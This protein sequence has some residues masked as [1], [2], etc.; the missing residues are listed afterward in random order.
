MATK[1]PDSRKIQP[2]MLAPISRPKVGETG[3]AGR[4]WRSL[5]SL[6]V[7]AVGLSFSVRAHAFSF[8]GVSAGATYPTPIGYVYQTLNNSVGGQAESWI[9]FGFLN[10]SN[11]LFHFGADVEPYN[12]RNTSINI[13]MAEIFAGMQFQNGV[14]GAGFLPYFSI[15]VGGVYEWM[16][17]ASVVNVSSNT[18]LAFAARAT[19]GFDLPL[20]GRFGINLETPFK[21]IFLTRP[22]VVWDAMLALRFKL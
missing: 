2:R 8:V 13:N 4:A 5:A 22:M 14:Y 6:W 15:D 7:A 18:A 21:V 19:P 12:I 17:L 1:V 20:V 3:L 11:F 16:T 10:P 9:D